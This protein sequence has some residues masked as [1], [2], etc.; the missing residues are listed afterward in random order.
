MFFQGFIKDKDIIQINN[1]DP[2][3]IFFQHMVNHSLDVVGILIN[4]N[5]KIK[6]SKCS[7]L[8]LN[9]IFYLEIFFSK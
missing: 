9:I 4:L 6:Y 8:V 7:N 5:N 1:D 3:D 2:I